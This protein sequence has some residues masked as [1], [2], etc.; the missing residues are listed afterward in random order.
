MPCFYAFYIEDTINK[1][2]YK[3]KF[4]MNCPM[5][6]IFLNSPRFAWAIAK[7]KTHKQLI[8]NCPTPYTIISTNQSKSLITERR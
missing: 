5:D 2:L 8:P 3:D 1:E 6:F 4:V 7:I